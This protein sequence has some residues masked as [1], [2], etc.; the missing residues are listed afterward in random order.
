[1]FKSIWS[2]FVSETLAAKQEKVNRH[3]PFPVAVIR[4][5][6]WPAAVITIMSRI[7]REFYQYFWTFLEDGGKITCE[8]TGKRRKESCVSRE[9]VPTPYR[10]RRQ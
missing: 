4:Q 5:Q 9:G 7:P 2:S 3:D 1:M 8:V 6:S 10:L